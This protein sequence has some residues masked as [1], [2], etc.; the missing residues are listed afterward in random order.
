MCSTP[1]SLRHGVSWRSS[2]APILNE[3]GPVSPAARTA[4]PNQCHGL[5]FA[6]GEEQ[7]G[8]DEESLILLEQAPVHAGYPLPPSNIIDHTR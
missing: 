1:S 4:V 6:I 2:L 7:S 3:P 8:T 5:M